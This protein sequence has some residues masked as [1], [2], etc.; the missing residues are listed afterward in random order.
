MKK[1]T[2]LMEKYT[3]KKDDQ[4]YYI[5]A[6]N[7]KDISEFYITKKDYGIIEF[8]IGFNILDCGWTTNKQV[9][10]NYYIEWI[11]LFENTIKRLENEV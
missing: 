4:V 3:I 6:N 7:V 11:T 2:I 8:M 1:E 5:L 9:I 10:D